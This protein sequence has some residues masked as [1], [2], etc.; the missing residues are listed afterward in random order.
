MK[1]HNLKP[2]RGS[3]KKKK[4][5]G[6]GNSSGS[7]NYSGRGSGG[8]R[9]RSGRAHFIGFEGGQ[10]PLYRRLP[11]RGFTPVRRKEYAIVN[12]KIL[13]RFKKGTE[14]TPELLCQEGIVKKDEKIKI[15]AEGEINSP[16]TLKVHKISNKA[17]E[18][19]VEK[20]GKVE[21]LS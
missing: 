12:L 14:I 17:R 1:L 8:A 20:G 11:K 6:R 21:I 3:V 7:G 19:I 16:L 13:E 5:L 10:M 9:S 4:R 18:K 2:A 15:L